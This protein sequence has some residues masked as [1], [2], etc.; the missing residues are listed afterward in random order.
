MPPDDLLN[1]S[2]NTHDQMR[3]DLTQASVMVENRRGYA[4]N[5][6]QELAQYSQAARL[7]SQ[8]KRVA[9]ALADAERAIDEAR[10][11]LHEM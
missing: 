6:A 4:N 9:K 3:Q 2:R 7:A 8:W 1:E 5:Y 11:T 10:H